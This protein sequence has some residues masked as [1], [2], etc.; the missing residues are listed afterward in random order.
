MSAARNGIT[1]LVMINGHGGN[2]PSLHFSAQMINRDAHI[3]TC[4]DTGETSDHDIEGMAETS[5][6]VHAGEIETS[7]ALA[8]RPELVRM[9]EAEACVP[10]FDSRYLDF[11]SRRGVGWY[12]YTKRISSSG[13]LGDP[14]KADAGKGRRMWDVMVRNLVELVEDLKGLS[15][16]EI[17]QRRY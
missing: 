6:D 3:F 16:D 13:V 11:S 17:H 2:G 15:L 1:K 10:R 4:V 5:N 9:E 12:A 14:T 7:T 8:L